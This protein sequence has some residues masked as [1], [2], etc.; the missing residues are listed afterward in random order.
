EDLSDA[1]KVLVKTY[2]N[3]DPY[4]HKFYDALVKVH[5]RN[6]DFSVRK[7]IDK[8]FV[9]HYTNV[10]NPVI[11][12]HIKPAIQRTGNKDFYLWGIFERTSCSYQL[13]EHIDIKK[14]ERSFPCPYKDILENIQKYLGTYEIEWKDV[15]NKWCIP[16]W[17]RFAE[18]AGVKM[19]AEPGEICKVRVL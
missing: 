7:G 9:E 4:P 19:K 11:E 14:N 1:L 16:V 8:E 12:R 2:S 3:I 10:L 5:L 13:Y 18:K 17:E 15:C 6:L